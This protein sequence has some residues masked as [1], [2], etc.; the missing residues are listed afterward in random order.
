MEQ[1]AIHFPH[2]PLTEQGTEERPGRVEVVK[3][4]IPPIN[5][6]VVRRKLLWTPSETDEFYR[7][8]AVQH[9]MI[10]VLGMS[11]LMPVVYQ[12]RYGPDRVH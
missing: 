9:E 4:K 7:V 10:S 2:V 11:T 3:G 1:L 8:R 5:S 6:I 12:T